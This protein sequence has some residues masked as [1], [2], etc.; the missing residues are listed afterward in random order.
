MADQ[1]GIA[2]QLEDCR[3]KA[4]QMGL[5]VV[6]EFV[7]ND[8]SA[9][10]KRGEKTGWNQMLR[11][12]DTGQFDALIVAATARLTRSLEDIL[13]V[14]SPKRDIRI[15]TVR[16]GIDTATNDFFLKMLALVADQEIHEKQARRK[17]YD[18]TR[19]LQGHPSPGDP[20]YGYDWVPRMDRDDKGTRYVIN[21]AQAEVVRYIF[22]EF[23]QKQTT[24]YQLTK[25]LNLT[26]A[27]IDANT[28]PRGSNRKTAS[29]QGL[30]TVKEANELKR[31]D[32]ATRYGGSWNSGHIRRMLMNPH[33]AAL[34]P[35]MS[36][37]KGERD[38]KEIDLGTCSPGAW[39]PIISEDL[40]KAARGIL[41]SRKPLH[42]GTA[43]KWL[44]GGL[45][46]C[47]VC[48][49]PVRSARGKTHPNARK[50]GSGK[51]PQKGY[52]SYRCRNNHFHRAGDPID[53]FI[54]EL[55]IARLSRPDA[56]ALFQ[57]DE[58]KEDLTVLT[59]MQRGLEERQRTLAMMVAE[60][61][62]APE[63]AKEAMEKIA[64]EQELLQERVRKATEESPLP[65]STDPKAVR[66]WW[67]QTSV[68]NRQTVVK[69]LMEIRIQP[70]GYGRRVG[71]S[72]PV[73]DTLELKLHG[74]D[75]DGNPT[76]KT[77]KW[78]GN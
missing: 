58:D 3:L 54:E 26:N 29:E 48:D 35:P 75:E 72:L 20:P 44:L 38:K 76:F 43:R 73:E 60:Q 27:E 59:G 34:L 78:T 62:M 17:R 53:K 68:A 71:P 42:Q 30:L 63:I 47:S 37:G 23:V 77:V 66:T 70:V 31:L 5:K 21:E 33:Y 69:T 65:A 8:V 19:H 55:C 64:A 45:A 13:E 46:R 9:T 16:E 49:E 2:Q 18:Q 61:G 22:K 36:G 51:A 52:H 40:L 14:T 50:D 12:Y 25:R 56:V 24:L 7:D 6:A 11:A 4:S 32:R 74:V 57:R 1:Q 15:L 10:K 41:L 39:E 67:N 28:A